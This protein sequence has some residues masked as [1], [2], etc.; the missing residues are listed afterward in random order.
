MSE[1]SGFYR[2]EV[3]D[4]TPYICRLRGRLKE[5]AQ[6]SDLVAIG[7]RVEFSAVAADGVDELHGIIE[8]VQ[9]RTSV[10]SRAVRTTGKRGGGQAEREHILIA[11]VTQ[12]FLVIAA[13]Q[14]SPNLRLL[15]RLLVTGEKA[16]LEQQVI[17]INKMDLADP[18]VL[19]TL[20]APYRQM[21]YEVL[22]TSAVTGS[23]IAALKARLP[24]QISVFTGPS[25][26]GKSSLLNQIQPELARA[27][28]EVSQYDQ[29]G[30]HTTRDSLLVRLAAG[31][32][33][34]D[35]PG[36]RLLNLWD[37]EPDELDAYFRDF[38]PHLP[39]CRFKDCTHTTEPHCAVRA[40]VKQ[41][42]IARS[43]YGSYLHLREELKNS[44]II[45]ER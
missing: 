3:A 39:H 22:F 37:V 23:G 20:V 7:D 34:A 24:D 45:Y 35:T 10:L 29:Q 13:A 32:Y 4:G 33:L 27:V 5:D 28:K 9:P 44:Y 15:D 11:N 26:V 30:V 12:A 1:Q 2:V 31:G 17:V 6:S 8:T 36:I 25:G 38:V 18:A 40:A 41:G 42:A 19:E 16:H 43:R 21:G 14:P